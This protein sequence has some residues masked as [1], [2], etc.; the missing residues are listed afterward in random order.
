MIV[1]Q[2]T[3]VDCTAVFEQKV[4]VWEHSIKVKAEK[5]PPLECRTYVLSL[6]VKIMQNS[7]TGRQASYQVKLSLQG[8]SLDVLRCSNYCS[9]SHVV[10]K[11]TETIISCHQTHHNLS[12]YWRPAWM[13]FS[14]PVYDMMQ[15]SYWN[16]HILF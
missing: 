8:I 2:D 6:S 13:Q 5:L 12:E 7:F 1:T 14:T 9:N 3:R 10:K 11:S 16:L 4:D 15:L